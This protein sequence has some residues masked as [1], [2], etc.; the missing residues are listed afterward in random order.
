MPFAPINDLGSL[1]RDPQVAALGMLQTIPGLDIPTMGL[2]VSFDGVRPAMRTPA[3]PLSP[4]PS[5]SPAEA[6]DVHR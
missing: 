6:A 5:Q 2:P 4:A 1:L 3:P